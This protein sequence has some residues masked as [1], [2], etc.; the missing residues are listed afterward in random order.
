M[1]RGLNDLQFYPSPENN[2]E[3]RSEVGGRG[4][5][6]GGGE[7]EE[8]EEKRRRR[9]RGGGRGEEKEEERFKNLKR[10]PPIYDS[11]LLLINTIA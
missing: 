7:E 8:A 1:K 6:G 11:P 2:R 10:L 4:E 9:R 3:G 5:V